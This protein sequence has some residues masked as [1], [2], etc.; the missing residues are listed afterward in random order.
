MAPTLVTIRFSHF[1]DK[2]RWALDHCGVAYHERAYLPGLHQIGTRP[3]GGRSTPLLV[4]PGGVLRQSTE[5]V[6]Y[7]DRHAAAERRLYPDDAGAR[8]EVDA[9]VA[10]MDASLGPATRRLAYHH[11]LPHPSVLVRAVGGGL[12]RAERLLFRVLIPAFERPMRRV[13]RI[14]EAGAERSVQAIRRTLDDVSARLRDGRRY[15]FG[16]R[17]GAADITFAA[18]SAPVVMPLGHPCYASDVSALPEPLRRLAEEAR[19]TAAGRFA[20]RLY[21][22]ERRY[23]G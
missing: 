5:I 15:L 13:M 2:A 14:D 22:E 12:S 20:T 19:A 21:A 3:H 18:L 17:L 1:C 16:D 4:T 6:G 11:L 9:F 8:A 10:E 7:A 23:Q